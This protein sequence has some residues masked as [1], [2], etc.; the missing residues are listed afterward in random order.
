MSVKSFNIAAAALG[1]LMLGAVAA[2][3]AAAPQA[4]PVNHKNKE[5]PHFFPDW[6]AVMDTAACSRDGH[7]VQ[8]AFKIYVAKN[9]LE[10]QQQ[11]LKQHGRDP[12]TVNKMVQAAAGENLSNMWA[13]LAA[14][15]DAGE[16]AQSALK[17]T[18]QYTG[19]LNASIDAV[20][21]K[22]D[23]TIFAE[24]IAVTDGGKT[25]ACQPR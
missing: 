13:T 18:P 12:Y 25:P 6:S 8:A 2:T 11:N 1:I 4:Q 22:T 16:L 23:V 10:T 3:E 15:R 24:L 14:G 9:H 19:L 5:I 7:A 20:H 17:S 21:Q